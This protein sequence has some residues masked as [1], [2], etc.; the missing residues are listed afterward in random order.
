MGFFDWFK[1]ENS[2]SIEENEKIIVEGNNNVVGT[3]HLEH[4]QSIN[5]T[6]SIIAI[7][8]V[9]GVVFYLIKKCWNCIKNKQRRILQKAIS[10][11]L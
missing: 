8:L 11:G 10:Q 1:T 2:P 6:L 4:L 3:Q 5:V 9:G 7:I